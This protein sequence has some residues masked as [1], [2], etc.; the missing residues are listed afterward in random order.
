[1]RWLEVLRA[2]R[3]GRL[4]AIGPRTRAE[5]YDCEVEG[6]FSVRMKV[7]AVRSWSL[8]GRMSFGDDGT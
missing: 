8:F 1:M 4:W 5:I 7:H 6:G 2:V 3:E